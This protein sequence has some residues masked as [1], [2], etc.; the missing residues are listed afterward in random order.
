MAGVEL[1]DPCQ[2]PVYDER[3]METNIPGLYVAG[4]AIGGTQDKYNRL[5]RELPRPRR[6]HRGGPDGRGAAAVAGACRAAGKLSP[7]MQI[8]HGGT[9]AR[10]LLNQCAKKVR[11]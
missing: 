10:L 4:T 2:S 1:R 5:H 11:P 3:T 7:K 6:S 8:H 9:E